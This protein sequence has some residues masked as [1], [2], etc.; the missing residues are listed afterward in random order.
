[1][2]IPRH[3]LRDTECDALCAMRIALAFSGRRSVS[4]GQFYE[5]REVA[6]LH[7]IARAWGLHYGDGITS[8]TSRTTHHCGNPAPSARPSRLQH[9]AA[10]AR[11]QRLRLDGGR[12]DELLHPRRVRRSWL[13]RDRHGRFVLALGARQQRWRVV[14]TQGKPSIFA[15]RAVSISS[16]RTRIVM[17]M[18][19]LKSQM[20]STENTADI[21]IN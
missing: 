15:H 10:R 19:S 6:A 13:R 3:W 7:H 18:A 12:A 17:G 8:L 21:T 1:M 16:M 5:L 9:R 11:H 4:R 14:S 20:M 2:G